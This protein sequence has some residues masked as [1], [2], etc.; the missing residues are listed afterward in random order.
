MTTEVPSEEQGEEKATATHRRASIDILRTPAPPRCFPV[1]GD[2]HQS[3]LTKLLHKTV[4]YSLVQ[5]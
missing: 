1:L 3:I 2:Q 4:H 5:D